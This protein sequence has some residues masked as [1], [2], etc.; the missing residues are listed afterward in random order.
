MLLSLALLVGVLAAALGFAAY[1]VQSNRAR[2]AVVRRT[3]RPGSIGVTPAKS[4]LL[5]TDDLSWQIRLGESLREVVPEALVDQS[6]SRRLLVQA[7]V[8]STAAPVLYAAVRLVALIAFPVIALGLMPQGGGLLDVAIYA[9]C[10]LAIGALAPPGLLSRAARQRQDRIR[11]GLPDALDLLVVCVEA[12]VSLDAAILRVARDMNDLHPDLAGE[13]MLINRRT[14]AGLP[15]D[16]VLHEMWP[17]TGV[18]EIRQLAS[19]MIQSEKWGTSIAKVLRVSSET[20]RRRR[21]QFAEKRAATA[22][23]KMMFP[24]ML[25]I[26]PALFI[27][28]LGPAAM[29]ISAAFK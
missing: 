10:G 7:G 12:G 15:R 22:S 18:E 4:P 16:E 14:N 26:M 5:A 2:A 1:A 11:R 27:V 29:N 23:I 3:A 13:F 25:L 28:L 17:R 24:V 19:S 21:R 9:G 8:E 6:A 20:L